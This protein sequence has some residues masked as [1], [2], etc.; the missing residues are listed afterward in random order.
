[1]GIELQSICCIDRNGPILLNIDVK[2]VAGDCKIMSE[3]QRHAK[4]LKV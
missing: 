3:N 1:M 4:V 2:V